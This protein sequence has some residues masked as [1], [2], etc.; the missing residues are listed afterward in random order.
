[1]LNT[2]IVSLNILTYTLGA[3]SIISYIIYIKE[4]YKLES[5]SK[6]ESISESTQTDKIEHDIKCNQTDF[7][8]DGILVSNTTRTIGIQCDIDLMVLEDDEDL[9]LEII[10]AQSSNYRWFFFK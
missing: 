8:I 9:N 7:E 4:L 10:P 6:P 2:P 3:I 1:M 5:I